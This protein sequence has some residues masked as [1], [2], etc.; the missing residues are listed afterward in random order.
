MDTQVY[1]YIKGIELY[2]MNKWIIW[3]V[4]FISIKLFIYMHNYPVSNG[5]YLWGIPLGK[6]VR[7]NSTDRKRGKI[8]VEPWAT[9]PWDA[10]EELWTIDSG[11]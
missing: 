5:Q 9:P 11:Q 10:A 6:G 3:Y 2:T 8:K 7:E 4:N 1:K